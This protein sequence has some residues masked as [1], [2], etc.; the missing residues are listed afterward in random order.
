[1]NI[2]YSGPPQATSPSAT[3]AT[4]GSWF[5]LI[6]MLLVFFLM[7]YFLVVIPQ[8]RK[9]KEFQRMIS[10]MKRGDT[11]ITVGGI[12]GRVIAIDKD[13]VKIKTANVTEIEITK[14]GI[15]T[16]IK[17]KEEKKEEKKEG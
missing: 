13:T 10:N 14:R 5:S 3:T 12:V 6:F 17:A 15:A 16:V 4:G 8:K 2:V 7:F 11:V 9:E 1:M